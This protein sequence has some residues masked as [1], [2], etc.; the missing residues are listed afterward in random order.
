[1]LQQSIDNVSCVLPDCDRA[2][3]LDRDL[4]PSHVCGPRMA[5]INPC[6][7]VLQLGKALSTSSIRTSQL[8]LHATKSATISDRGLH[9]LPPACTQQVYASAPPCNAFIRRR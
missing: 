1:M 8:R 9:A 5:E 2:A 3:R 7:S 6:A 4:R